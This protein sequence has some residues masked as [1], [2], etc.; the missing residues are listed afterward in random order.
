MALVPDPTYPIHLY[1]M[2]IAGANVRSV[3]LVSGGDFFG[4]IVSAYHETWPRPKYLV[5]SFPHNPTCA[6]VE[7]DFFARVVEFARANNIIV[8]HDLA[9]ADLT[10]DGYVAPS[11][12]QIPGAKD[13]GVEFFSLSKSYNMPGWRVGF[14]VGNPAI[15]A[16]LARIKSY[17]DYG[18]FQPI[19][20]PSIIAMNGPQ[21]CVAET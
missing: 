3:P 4:S 10:F 16:A 19:Q 18:M 2:I 8:I 17:L 6:T 9:Y 7:L 13:V 15:V 14:C 12:L 11:M 5:L 21:E 20:L 1:S